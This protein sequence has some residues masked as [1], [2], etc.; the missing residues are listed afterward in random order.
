MNFFSKKHLDSQDN[1]FDNLP[2]ALLIMDN[3]GRVV[4]SNI[5]SKTLLLKI[6]KNLGKTSIL[7][8]L[9]QEDK[10][11]FLN[12]IKKVLEGTKEYTSLILKNCEDS[13]Y[14]RYDFASTLVV[15]E[16]KKFV[17]SSISPHK[18]DDLKYEIFF[19]NSPLIYQ[20][21]D[22][23]GKFIDINDTFVNTFGYSKNEVIGN[24][25]GNFLSKDSLKKFI[26]TFPA[27]KKSKIIENV[28]FEM[29]KKN[30][31]ILIVSINGKV[32]CDES[33]SFKHT[34]CLLQD[35][36]EQTKILE[37]LVISKQYYAN[38]FESVDEGIIYANKKG[39]VQKVNSSFLKMTSLERDKVINRHSVSLARDHLSKIKLKNIM[40]IISSNLN[41]H[42]TQPFELEYLDRVFLISTKTSL[43]DFGVIAVFRD[44]TE[45]KK[46]DQNSETA[47]EIS[48]NLAEN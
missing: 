37:D 13:T 34:H 15:E 42:N 25:F 21:L 39:Y 29:I 31:D 1:I 8:A 3:R 19:N 4:K 5:E 7:D 33:G 30:G 45:Q 43:T 24:W 22:S 41:G 46:K 16:N 12:H 47:A 27:F 23:E 44:I 14:S 11:T 17:S 26:V 32:V 38:I 20:S 40:R 6:C 18:E 9:D 48:A 36:T 2:V 28:K 10:S 35:V